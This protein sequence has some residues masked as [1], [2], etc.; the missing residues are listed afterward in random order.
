MTVDWFLKL[1]K[2]YHSIWPL[3]WSWRAALTRRYRSLFRI[4]WSSI[5]TNKSLLDF[6]IKSSMNLMTL[7]STLFWRINLEILSFPVVWTRQINFRWKVSKMRYFR[8]STKRYPNSYITKMGK[9]CCRHV[10]STLKMTKK[11]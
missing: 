1:P 8:K 9:K 2:I 11:L 7:N 5:L 3:R 4:D 6:I 10:S